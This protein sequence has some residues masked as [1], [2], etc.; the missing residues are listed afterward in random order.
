MLSATHTHVMLRSDCEPLGPVINGGT[1]YCS[2][3]LSAQQVWHGADNATWFT[4]K[5]HRL[6]QYAPGH[7]SK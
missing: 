6:G 1:S 5:D 3:W 4:W 2:S 7:R